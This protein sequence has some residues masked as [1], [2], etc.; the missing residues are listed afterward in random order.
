MSRNRIHYLWSE[1]FLEHFW[2]KLKNN[3]RFEEFICQ[4]SCPFYWVAIFQVHVDRY[5]AQV[6]SGSSIVHCHACI[7]NDLVLFLCHHE[8]YL[9]QRKPPILIT[10]TLGVKPL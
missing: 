7:F 4:D 6:F 3:L 2:W 1:S 5:L 9:G 10:L 8:P